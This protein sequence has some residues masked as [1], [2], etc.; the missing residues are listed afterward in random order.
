MNTQD[1]S[2]PNSPSRHEGNSVDSP[3]LRWMNAATSGLILAGLV[4][5][6]G[7]VAALFY[8]ALE[9]LE[10]E[11]I[12]L[13]Y[14][15]LCYV[16]SAFAV[17]SAVLVFLRFKFAAFAAKGQRHRVR[18][19][20]P[21]GHGDGRPHRHRTRRAHR[22]GNSA[23]LFRMAGYRGSGYQ[24]LRELGY[25]VCGGRNGSLVGGPC[26]SYLVLQIIV[27][28]PV[29]LDLLLCHSRV[30][31][32]REESRSFPRSSI[33]IRD[34]SRAPDTRAGM[35]EKFD[36]ADMRVTILCRTQISSTHPIAAAASSASFR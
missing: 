25:L 12:H 5:F 22:A 2:A 4:A 34:S 27:T 7:L 31:L 10:D 33:G 9:D 20:K 3:R 16:L 18:P 28:V 1:Q 13:W 23:S 35:T 29:L 11:N 36:R 8:L 24:Q 32:P 30:W 17:L 21:H 26:L 6:F 14:K 15:A 19:L